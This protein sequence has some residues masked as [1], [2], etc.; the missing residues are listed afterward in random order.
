MIKGMPWYRH[1]LPIF[2][3]VTAVETTDVRL[4]WNLKTELKS[5]VEQNNDAVH[6]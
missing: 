4:Y 5:Y 6:P 3:T 2:E 1:V